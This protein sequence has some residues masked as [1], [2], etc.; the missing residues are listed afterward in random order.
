MDQIV[1][2]ISGVNINADA[3]L[4]EIQTAELITTAV[5][6]AVLPHI[7][8]IIAKG[9]RLRRLSG[10]I[11]PLNII[12]CE[13]GVRASSQLK[14]EVQK[15]LNE[16][17]QAYLDLYVGFPDCSVDRIVPPVKSENPTDVVVESFFEWNVEEKS[18]K[19]VAPH[20]N[21]MNLADNLI[22]YIE[23]KLFTLNTG[24]AITAYLGIL[25]GYHTIDE[26]IADE[27]IYT[28]VK[29]AMQEAG[30]GLI[31]KYKF[32][33]ESHFKYIDKIINRLRNPNLK[34]DLVRVCREPLRKLSP[35]DRLIKPLLIAR[36]YGFGV[37]NLLLGVGAALHY[38]N[39]DDKQSVE[40]QNLIKTKGLKAAVSEITGIAPDDLILD[41]IQMS[42]DSVKTKLN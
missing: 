20:I 15:Y 5:G 39:A 14:A 21:G 29:A 35:N 33:K 12:A 11:E 40:L 23:R 30:S 38:E 16:E 10:T 18:F 9:I 8:P 6:L 41:S 36:E 22:S 3:L 26:S 27:Q 31:N 37:E 34:D 7:A 28:I 42:Y 1:T 17:D 24:H 32:N 25:K 19:G 4:E 2:N 13:N